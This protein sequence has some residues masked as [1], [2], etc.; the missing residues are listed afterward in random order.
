V[1]RRAAA[2]FLGPARSG[3]AHAIALTPRAK[4]ALGL[5]LREALQLGHDSVGGEHLLLGLIQQ[6]EGAAVQ[7]LVELGADAPALRQK[8]LD[9]LGADPQLVELLAAYSLIVSQDPAS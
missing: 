4:T 7:A 9:K 3:R 6:G 5:A 8:L 2:G 1:S